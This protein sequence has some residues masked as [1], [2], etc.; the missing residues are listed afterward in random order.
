[1]IIPV[2]MCRFYEC[3]YLYRKFIICLI[4]FRESEEYFNG[5]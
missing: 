1:M 2:F 4:W 3:F 5:I